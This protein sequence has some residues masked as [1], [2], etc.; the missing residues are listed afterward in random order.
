LDKKDYTD[1]DDEV[2]DDDVAFTTDE[3][4][5]YL[6]FILSLIKKQNCLL[7]RIC[8]RIKLV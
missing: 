8:G 4:F 2:D 1:D 7:Q 5:V 6:F 3:K